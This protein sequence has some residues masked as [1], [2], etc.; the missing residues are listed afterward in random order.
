[1][2][3]PVSNLRGVPSLQITIIRRDVLYN[4]QIGATEILQHSKT[5]QRP[6]E[7]AICNQTFRS[8]NVVPSS[9]GWDPSGWAI[10]SFPH[11]PLVR[12]G[13]DV[14]QDVRTTCHLDRFFWALLLPFLICPL[15][16]STV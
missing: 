5:L 16:P 2:F 4:S 7:C 3:I 14:V 15:S 1:M 11:Q 9:S 6:R 10:T 12:W 13:S 8:E